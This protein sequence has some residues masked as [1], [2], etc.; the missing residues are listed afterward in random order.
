[1]A[2]RRK[3]RMQAASAAQ[4]EAAESPAGA[5]AQPTDEGE[6]AVAEGEPAP[7]PAAGT[8]ARAAALAFI[9]LFLLFQIAMPL[10]YYLGERGS[11]ERFSWRMFSSVRMQKCR[12][13]LD[14][15]VD[16]ERRSVDLDR[17]VQ[18]AWIGMLERYRPTVVEKVLRRRCER[19]GAT[20]VDFERR[21]VDTDG[22]VLPSLLVGVDC[23]SGDLTAREGTAEADPGAR[24]RPR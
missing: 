21:C 19:G 7:Q 24:S 5:V 18:V 1:M 2:N 14:E 13:R 3:R 10:R 23:A 9:A 12:V 8:R 11:D 20:R 6:S 4:A 15:T 17:E 16:G 22:S